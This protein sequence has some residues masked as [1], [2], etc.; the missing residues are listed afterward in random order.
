[1]DDF[2]GEEREERLLGERRLEEFLR[3]LREVRDGGV[4]EVAPDREGVGDV[5][6]H[7]WFVVNGMQTRG[8]KKN[9]SR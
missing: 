3:G 9:E 5:F 8:I 7:C 6:G 1:M 2:E 4:E